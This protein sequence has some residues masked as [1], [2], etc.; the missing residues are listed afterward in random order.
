MVVAGPAVGPD[1][2]V[3]VVGPVVDADGALGGVVSEATG[4]GWL[5]G[6]GGGAGSGL[7]AGGGG[8]D[9]LAGAEPPPRDGGRPY[10]AARGGWPISL[11]GRSVLR[12]ILRGCAMMAMRSGS[13]Y[14]LPLFF[15][16]HG[17]LTATRE[18][19]IRET[20]NQ[21]SYYNFTV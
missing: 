11:A 2:D 18:R 4:G 3:V 13:L 1:V 17:S 9:F 12:W 20:Q 7:G 5:D 19:Q 21:R 15:R 16:V 10:R 14:F 8:A 6:G